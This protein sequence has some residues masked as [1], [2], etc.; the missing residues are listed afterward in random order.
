MSDP[1]SSVVLMEASRGL[2]TSRAL[3]AISDALGAVEHGERA[4][5]SAAVRLELVKDARVVFRR[6]EALLGVLVAEADA[7]GASLVARGTPTTSWLTLDGTPSGEAA[8]L[9][10]AGQDVTRHQPVQDA[11]LLGV[12]SV[13]QAR[14]IAKVMTQLP[15]GLDTAQQDAAAQVLVDM[16]GRLDPKRPEKA[17]REVLQKVAPASMPTAEDEQQRLEAQRI[18]AFARRELVFSPDGDGAVRIRGCLPVLEASQLEKLVDAYVEAGRRAARD[19]K[20]HDG[21]ATA[22]VGVP[23]LDGPAGVAADLLTGHEAVA[24]TARLRSGIGRSGSSRET[25]TPGQRRADALMALVAAHEQGRRAPGVGGD[26]PRVVVTMREGELR[27]RAEQAGVLDNGAQISAGE[28]RRLCCDA[29]LTLAVL[30]SNSEVLD[31]GTTVRLVTPAIRRALTL[32]DKGCVF[33]GCQIAA[34]GCEAHHVIPW[35]AGGKTALNNLVL[36]C[37]HHHALLEPPRFFSGAPPDRWQVRIND[38]G[39]PEITPPRRL[40]VPDLIPDVDDGAAVERVRPGKADSVA[41]GAAQFGG[42]CVVLVVDSRARPGAPDDASRASGGLVPV[43]GGDG[44]G[45]ETDSGLPGA[46]YLPARSERE[47]VPGA[48]SVSLTGRLGGLLRAVIASDEQEGKCWV[49]LEKVSVLVLPAHV[50]PR[51]PPTF[52][53]GLTTGQPSEW[54]PAGCRRSGPQI[55]SGRPGRTLQS[56]EPRLSGDL[57]EARVW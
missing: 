52:A 12:V 53:V 16:A 19:A 44:A 8:G 56:P 41:L 14:T 6:M 55:L 46:D 48:G 5:L 21:R 36:L 51:G 34:D 25:V 24:S 7:A 1:V 28:L 33:P 9:V 30:G 29:D 23:F 49:S 39:M 11:A 15:A 10:F 45:Q 38:H 50:A 35:W 17:V 27:G 43:L 2:S 4:G 13:R 31:V 57:T 54:L 32:R 3:V 18:R 40:A 22:E 37:P 42:G 26:R 20:Q 47:G